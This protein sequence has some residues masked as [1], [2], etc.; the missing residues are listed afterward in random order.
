[1]CW[2]EAQVNSVARRAWTRAAAEY[3]KPRYRAGAGVFTGFG[4]MSGIFREAGIPLRETLHE[5][6]GPQWLGAAHRPD[7]LLREEW[8]VAQSGDKVSAAILRTRKSG[9][10]YECVRMFSEK[11]APVLE[12]YRR[13]P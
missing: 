11:G 4:D 3:L 5:G 13:I 6:N 1:V 10:R 8:A 12:I 9:P 2:K 7:L